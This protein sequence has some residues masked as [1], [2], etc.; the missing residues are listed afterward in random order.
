MEITTALLNFTSYRKDGYDQEPFIEA[1]RLDFL[2]VEEQRAVFNHIL[3]T[4]RTP[5]IEETLAYKGFLPLE[6]IKET[7]GITFSNKDKIYCPYQYSWEEFTL[8]EKLSDYKLSRLGGDFY[9]KIAPP[10]EI[11]DQID[12]YQQKLAHKKVQDEEKKRARKIKKAEKLLKE[13]GK[14]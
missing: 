10:K 14:I 5:V 7:K 9:I 3:S 13:A 11:Q 4:F 12:A 1:K 6:K 8:G 2:S